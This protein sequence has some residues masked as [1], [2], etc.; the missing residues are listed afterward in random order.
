V[1]EVQSDDAG[2]HDKGN[3]RNTFPVHRGDS[4]DSGTGLNS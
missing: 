1:R 3:C 2:Q 4:D